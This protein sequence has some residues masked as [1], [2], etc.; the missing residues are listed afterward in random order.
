MENKDS[1]QEYD[2]SEFENIPI[3]EV[4]VFFN[5]RAYAE[6]GNL[7]ITNVGDLLRKD[8]SGEL[9]KT[10]Y[11]KHKD[12]HELWNSIHDTVSFLKYKYL[13]I[14]FN[15][16]V[17]DNKEFIYK[18]G[19]S[20]GIRKRLVC[21]KILN[22]ECLLKMVDENDFSM[23]YTHFTEETVEEIVSKVKVI[24]EYLKSKSTVTIDDLKA[25]YE[26]LS[27]LVKEYQ[28]LGDEIGIIQNKINLIT[29]YKNSTFY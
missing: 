13:G 28:R 25:L 19:F 22:I 18:S 27:I 7:N 12:A 4:K 5:N 11:Q 14:E 20:R 6:L 8:I 23:L 10:F 24:S 17:N 9:I 16:D 29:N 3:E 15:F 1:V 2:Y 21:F 26:E